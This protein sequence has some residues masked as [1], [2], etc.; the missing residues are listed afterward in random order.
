[1]FALYNPSDI[2]NSLY[3]SFQFRPSDYCCWVHIWFVSLRNRCYCAGYCVTCYV[4]SQR[5]D[6]SSSIRLVLR[7]V[8]TSDVLNVS[9]INVDPVS[10]K[11]WYEHSLYTP[12]IGKHVAATD[13]ASKFR[14]FCALISRHVPRNVIF[15][16]FY[17]L[18]RFSFSC[19]YLFCSYFKMFYSLKYFVIPI[20]KLYTTAMKA[21]ISSIFW[22]KPTI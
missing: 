2:S 15:P 9:K 14:R 16:P 13:W 7:N 3:S 22:G 11:N 6:L 17:I 12:R 1:M 8:K 18:S 5:T 10:L 21:G 20:G 19:V 4:S